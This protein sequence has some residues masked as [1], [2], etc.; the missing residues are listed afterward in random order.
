[1]VTNLG[2]RKGAWT[3]EEDIRLRKCIGEH[4]EG[5]WHLVSLKAGLNRCRK[6]CRQ[7]W[8]N[9]LRPNIK[10]GNF[11]TDEVDLIIR[12]HNLLGN[13]WSLIAGRLPGRTSNDVKNYWN[14]NMHKYMKE[15]PILDLKEVSVIKPQPRV[16][17]KNFTVLSGKPT[18]KETSFRPKDDVI[19][20]TS[21]TMAS[22][23]VINTC[24]R[25]TAQLDNFQGNE[26]TA[27]RISELDEEPDLWW[28]NMLDD[29][30]ISDVQRATCT[31]TS[32]LD[33][34]PNHWEKN[35]LNDGGGDIQRAAWS[36][37]GFDDQEPNIWEKNLLND[38][39]GDIQRAACSTISGFDDQELNI[40]ANRTLLPEAHFVGST[41]DEDDSIC[42]GADFSFDNGLWDFPNT[43]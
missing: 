12:L 1:M 18:I 2:L 4:G 33:K 19:R 40:W 20:N 39:E 29:S 17:P 3:A 36:M 8:L 25:W 14:I 26:R 27:C 15:K 35:V 31:I 21:P 16:L 5:N 6:S 9:Y 13:R 30:E 42:T 10:R 11:S 24:K 7:R 38:C 41:F 37:S 23:T 43:K 32:E 22:S 34:E 28:K